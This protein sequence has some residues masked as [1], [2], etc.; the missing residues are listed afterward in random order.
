MV[1]MSRS[2]YRL[3]GY[4][5]WQ[6]GKWYLRRRHVPR[7]RPSARALATLGLVACAGAAAAGVAI[8]RRASG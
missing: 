4:L 7:E 3:L 2:G 5:V 1:P 6:G 8:V